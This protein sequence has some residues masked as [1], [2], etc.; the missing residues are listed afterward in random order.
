MSARFA[1]AAARRG[2]RQFDLRLGS[3]N[4]R[5]IFAGDALAGPF[6]TAFA[7]LVEQTPSADPGSDALTVFLWDSASTGIQPAAP[8]WSSRDFQ[9]RGEVNHDF[10]DRVC[11]SFR[12]D[13]GVLSV[14]APATNTALCWVRDPA[15]LPP[16][17]VAAPLRP[18]LAWWAENTGR[19]LAHGAGIGTPGGAVL[20]AARGGSG[21][22]T[23]AL[24]CL[25]AGFLYLG[26]DYVMLEPGSPP[27]VSSLYCTAKLVPSNLDDRLP[28]LRKLVTGRHD[29]EQNKVTLS[30]Y[31]AF[32]G[33]ITDSLPLRA[34]VIPSLA[35][36]RLSLRTASAAAALAALAPTTLF[37]LPNA[38]AAALERMQ[39][40][41]AAIPRYHLE[42][43]RDPATNVAAL[44][45][46]IEGSDAA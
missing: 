13:S 11:L 35:G 17:E 5:L 28:Q 44:R 18:I 30:L 37:Q 41:I 24:S 20:L 10:G 21:K 27:I 3:G 25:E 46:L 19:Q 29:I 7:H 9:A 14:F 43:D 45:S 26:D 23:T 39:T 22:S 42:L 4:A 15:T 34:I 16:W 1:L 8:P 36:G 31:D 2:R 40:I 12:I 32:R 6:G 38:G 33:S